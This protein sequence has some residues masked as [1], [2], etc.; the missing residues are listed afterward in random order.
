MRRLTFKIFTENQKFEMCSFLSAMS[1]KKRKFTV[2]PWS[3][4][5]NTGAG[6]IVWY[7]W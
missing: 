4:G 7:Q 6:F 2:T 5:D 3:S 1:G